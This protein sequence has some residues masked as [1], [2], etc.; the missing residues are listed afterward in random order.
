MRNNINFKSYQKANILVE[1]L[2]KEVSILLKEAICE[3]NSA[4]FLVS[5]GNTPKLFFQ[6]LS[7]VKLDWSLVKIGL[8]DERWI[9]ESNENSNAHLVKEFLLQNE[10]SK[11]EFISLF[12]KEDITKAEERCSKTYENYFTHCDVLILGMGEDGH[13]ASIFP[14][15]VK[16][17][18]ALDTKSDKFCISI[19][20]STAPYQRMSLTLKA[21]LD[22]KNLFLHIQNEK[23]L[24]TYKNALKNINEYPISKILF[25]AKE[26][27]VYYSHE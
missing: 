4:T 25:N 21:I 15:N 27:K 3:K 1:N 24:N 26:L 7:K 5:G 16:T 9:K 20:P 18:E 2:V 10:A 8:V 23:K 13:T 14:N 11:A 17:E 6:E 22:S 19:N 12:L